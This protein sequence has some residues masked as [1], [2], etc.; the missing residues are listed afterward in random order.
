MQRLLSFIPYS[1]LIE[2]SPMDIGTGSARRRRRL[3]V[4]A[5]LRDEDPGLSAGR[6]PI[7]VDRRNPYIYTREDAVYLPTADVRVNFRRVDG[8]RATQLEVL[9]FKYARATG[10]LHYVGLFSEGWEET[11]QVYDVMNDHVN[12]QPR[13]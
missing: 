4:V 11:E 5:R 2:R 3:P 12:V 1:P 8:L 10:Q 13:Q 7:R 6:K 9:P